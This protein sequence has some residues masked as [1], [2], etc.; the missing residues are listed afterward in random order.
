ML[1]FICL[2]FINNLF[3]VCY[4]LFVICYTDTDS[5]FTQTPL[6]SHLSS[7][8]LGQ[9]KLERYFNEIIFLSPKVYTGKYLEGTLMR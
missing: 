7:S 5:I 2:L 8:Q 9:L 4:L 3:D 6:P 1:E